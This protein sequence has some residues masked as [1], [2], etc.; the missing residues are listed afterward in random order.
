M[1]MYCFCYPDSKPGDLFINSNGVLGFCLEGVKRG[2][3]SSAITL[4]DDKI[5]T[6][7]SVIKI[8]IVCGVILAGHHDL[9]NSG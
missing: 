4:L 1:G 9:L 2:R 6:S 8:P 7:L 5:P 3:L